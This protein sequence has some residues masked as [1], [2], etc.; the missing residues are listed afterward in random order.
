MWLQSRSSSWADAAL[1]AWICCILLSSS[2]RQFL[3]KSYLF[4][5]NRLTEGTDVHTAMGGS[6]W[7]QSET[8]SLMSF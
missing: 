6:G 3:T 1:L 5:T 4:V 2:R 7:Q 8:E